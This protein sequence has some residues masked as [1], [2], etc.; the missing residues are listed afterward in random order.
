ML[1]D[2]NPFPD[3]RAIRRLL[4]EYD[5]GAGQHV[6]PSAAVAAVLRDGSAGPEVLLIR[7]SARDRD[8]WSGQMAFPGGRRE[9]GDPAILDTAIRET[10]EEVGLDLRDHDLLCALEQVPT[11]RTGLVVA[12]FVFAL[13]GAADLAPNEEVAE[14]VWAPLSRMHAGEIDSVFDYQ[15]EGLSVPLPAFDVDG[16][17][18]WGLTYRMLRVLF[19]VLRDRHR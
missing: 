12:P 14:T 9:V 10:L 18:V 11:H 13:R 3:L 15:H 5:P 2:L 1:V 7:R 16:R 19:D 4:A 17:I 8:P 6:E